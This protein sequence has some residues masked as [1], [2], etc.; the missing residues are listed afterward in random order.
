MSKI[1]AGNSAESKQ[2]LDCVFDDIRAELASEFNEVLDGKF[3][4]YN[5]AI[6]TFLAQKD[7]EQNAIHEVTSKQVEALKIAQLETEEQQK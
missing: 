5:E 4:Q 7:E 1:A 6:K 3:S 2:Q